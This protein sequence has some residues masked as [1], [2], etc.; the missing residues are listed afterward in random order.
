[1]PQ[2]DRLAVSKLREMARTYEAEGRVPRAI[3]TWRRVAR[4]SPD[5][6]ESRTHLAALL[7][8]QSRYAEA[9][10]L[11]AEAAVIWARSGEVE[12]AFQLVEPLVD[13]LLATR[14]AREAARHLEQILA[15]GQATPRALKK[16][17]VAYQQMGRR[18]DLVR[19]YASLADADVR[20]EDGAL[21]LRRMV[22][23][24]LGTGRGKT[25]RNH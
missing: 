12:A 22:S 18:G 10:A 6:P 11:D 1:M 9:M 7:R 25:E 23:R 19:L 16:L 14:H 2:G 20:R 21:G 13:S 24:G 8:R 3:R 5:D 17:A 4:Q 15:H